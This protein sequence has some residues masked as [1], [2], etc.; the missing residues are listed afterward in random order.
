M[1]LTD[2]TNNL[3]LAALYLEQGRYTEAE[4]LFI[5]ALSF[6]EELSCRAARLYNGKSSNQEIA[7]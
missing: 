4:P 6:L 5:R 3:N 7:P 2:L 1:N